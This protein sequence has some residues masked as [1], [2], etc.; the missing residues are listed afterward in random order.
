MQ[1]IV[2]CKAKTKLFDFVKMRLIVVAYNKISYMKKF[3]AFIILQLFV[4]PSA[5]SQDFWEQLYFPDT[6]QI[7]CITINEND[8]IF[9]GAG[10]NGLSGGVYRSYDDGTNWDLLGL[11]NRSISSVA[12]NNNG[13]IYAGASQSSNIEGLFRSDDDGETWESILPDIGVYGNIIA[14]LPLG[15]T[16]FVSLWM[17]SGSKLI[18][19]IDNGQN[20]ELIFSNENSTEHITDIVKTNSGKLYIG[21]RAYTA[22]MGGIY[23]SDDGGDN[24]EYSGL[25]NYQVLA[26]AYNSDNDVFAATPGGFND[27]LLPGLYVLRNGE[28]DWEELIIGPGAEDVI[29]NSKDHIFFSSSWP[30]GV[31]RSVDNGQT[32]EFVNEGLPEVPMEE[33]SIDNLGYLYVST[34]FSSNFL[35]RSVNPTVSAPEVKLA[36]FEDPWILYP[37]PADNLVNIEERFINKSLYIKRI[38]IYNKFGDLIQTHNNHI[39]DHHLIDVSGLAPGLYLVEIHSGKTKTIAKIIVN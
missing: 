37:N 21:L 17:S 18:C 38:H 32:Y 33:L 39:D 5:F 15:D 2:H 8:H 1:Y 28:S 6:T 36:S 31:A 25:F 34:W 19:S 4:N 11:E 12:I 14:I 3:F 9:I 22:Y 10:G 20:W 24:W 27:T 26:L 30:N 23:K 7:R 29:V 16:I 13:D 35:A